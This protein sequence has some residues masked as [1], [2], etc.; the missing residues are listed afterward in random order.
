MKQIQTSS[1]LLAILLSLG[2]V[3][4]L[5]EKVQAQESFSPN[6]VI[7]DGKNGNAYA[8]WTESIKNQGVESVSASVRRL[9]GTNTTYVNI[10]FQDGLTFENGK[11]IYL[12]DDRSRIVT[13]N[14]GGQ[15]S[16]GKPL[17]LMAYGGEVLLES[18]EIRYA[19]Q[20]QAPHSG[21]LGAGGAI[22]Q[23]HAGS[24]HGSADALARCREI[25]TRAPRIEL[26]RIR[27]VSGA[28]S[29][30]Y[31]V[32]GSVHGQCIQEVG[33][34]ENGRLKERIDFPLDDRFQRQEFEIRVQS[35]RRGELRAYTTDGRDESVDLDDELSQAGQNN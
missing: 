3:L 24:G 15:Q 9:K 31:R 14:G 18:I 30:K 1:L 21:G 32:E 20:A 4:H 8:K 23:P 35:G 28:F 33:Y 5:T 25:R 17:T 10:R 12:T 34:F 27:P 2:M 6:M 26:G 13:W 11:R 22:V 19:R 29:G 7:G 16:G